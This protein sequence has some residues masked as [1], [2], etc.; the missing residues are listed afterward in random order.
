MKQ[1]G[2]A[3]K[4]RSQLICCKAFSPL[5]QLSLLFLLMMIGSLR[6]QEFLVMNINTQEETVGSAPAFFV[7]VGSNVFYFKA[8]DG[9][10]GTELWHSDGTSA[11]TT[12]VADIAASSANADPGSL[13]NVN[14]TLF[15]SATDSVHGREL[16]K[17][18]G[19]AG[20]TGLVADINP[21][22]AS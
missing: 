20:G 3:V 2:G 14:G 4:S 13:V 22:S 9:I 5:G 1:S 12:L 21:G 15:F 7:P 6:A 19:T 16:W 17:S 18:D 10:H 11:G 8:N